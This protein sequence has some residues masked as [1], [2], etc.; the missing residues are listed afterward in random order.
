MVVK[1]ILVRRNGVPEIIFGK[2]ERFHS[3]IADREG[4]ARSQIM[5]GGY[6]DRV[7]KRI[8]GIS[9]A[10][11]PYDQEIVQHLLPD[12]NILPSSSA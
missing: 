11:G 5:G 2:G 10:F 3:G 7:E 12:W 8:Y 1:F 4:I 6:A 9:K